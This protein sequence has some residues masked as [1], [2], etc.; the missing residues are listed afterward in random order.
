MAEKGEEL[1][2]DTILTAVGN[3]RGMLQILLGL[4]LPEECVVEKPER[5]AQNDKSSDDK[6]GV[7]DDVVGFW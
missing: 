1:R 7:D 2:L 5:T 4:M 6:E 3:Q